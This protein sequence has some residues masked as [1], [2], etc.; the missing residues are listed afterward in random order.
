NRAHVFND[1]D[2]AENRRGRDGAAVGLVVKRDV[3]RD[4]RNLQGLSCLRD[5]LDRLR[6]LPADLGLLGITEVEAVGQR[7]R[8]AAG[9]RDLARGSKYSA[10][11]R[12]ERVELPDSWSVERD[13]EP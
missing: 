7:E 10:R 12:G 9:A 5:S 2:A 4:D 11:A 1:A 8:T 6:K 13:G 3:A